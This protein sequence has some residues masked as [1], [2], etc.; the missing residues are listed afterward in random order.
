MT[1]LDAFALI[2]SNKQTGDRTRVV[3]TAA[4]ARALNDAIH[5]NVLLNIKKKKC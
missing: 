1:N 3:T 4:A 5:K 2:L